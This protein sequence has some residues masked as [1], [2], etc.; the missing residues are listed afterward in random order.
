MGR[1]DGLRPGRRTITVAVLAGALGFGLA[2]TMAWG[3]AMLDAW[4]GYGETFQLGYV[5][6]YIDAVTLEKRHD[7]RVWIPV[8]NKPDYELWRKRV[9]DFFADPANAK[10]PIAN[11][12]A[13]AG[14]IFQD[15]TLKALKDMRE[16]DKL[17]PSPAPSGATSP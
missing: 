4:N 12:M 6:G 2:S 13:A 7:M 1:P 16:Q 15:E 11:G 17:S 3:Y 8:Y 9:N 10:K 5:V 14:K